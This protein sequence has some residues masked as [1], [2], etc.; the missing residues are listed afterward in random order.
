[1]WTR[2]GPSSYISGVLKQ[3]TEYLVVGLEVK[4]GEGGSTISKY[5]RSAQA[6]LK[7]AI[8]SFFLGTYNPMSQSVGNHR[9][10][11]SF[12][13]GYI[14][15]GQTKQPALKDILRDPFYTSQGAIFIC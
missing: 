10:R 9:K 12:D 3:G 13:I 5:F 14:T 8:L 2:R 4:E 15:G 1:M 6:L 11:S 7:L